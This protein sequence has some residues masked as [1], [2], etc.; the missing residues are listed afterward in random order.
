MAVGIAETPQ[1]NRVVLVSTS[2]ANRFIRS[3]V[4]AL[5]RSDEIFV[6]GLTTHAEQNIVVFAE[7]QGWEL[8]TV[9]AGRPICEVCMA[10]L[11]R[12]GARPANPRM[13]A[14]WWSIDFS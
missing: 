10:E 14:A 1:G 12:V 6:T 3:G 4:A 8:I 5:K 13:V 2:E 7:S 9:A 11:V